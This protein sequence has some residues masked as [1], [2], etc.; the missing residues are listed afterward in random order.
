MTSSPVLDRSDPGPGER[1]PHRPGFV[2]EKKNRRAR[3]PRALIAS[4][5]LI[6]A[7]LTLP[8]IFLLIEASSSGAAA[9]ARLIFRPLTAELL[10]NTVRLTVVV[11]ALCAVIGT[12]AAWCV[13]RTNVPGRNIWA[14]LVVVP[15][16]IPDFV[17]S[18]R[19]AS[20]WT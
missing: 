18:F 1:G 13:E 5:T 19:L 10:W 4:A 15:L 3:R 6:A 16:A 12:A 9:D 7:V 8:L 11:T 14:V 2:A 17:V 20:L